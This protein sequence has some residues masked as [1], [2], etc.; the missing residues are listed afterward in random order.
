MKTI[1]KECYIEFEERKSKF[2]GYIKPVDTK[3]AAENFIAQ[4]KA[5]HKDATHNCSAYKLIENGQEYFKLNDDGEP[6][7]TAGKPMGDVINFM[8][9]CNLVVVATRYFGGIKLGA[10]GLIRAYAKTTKEAI[11]AAGIIDYIRKKELLIDLPYDKYQ[12][13]EKVIADLNIEILD[14]SYLDKIICKIL[15]PEEFIEKLKDV[16]GLTIII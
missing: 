2:I 15:L 3:E 9:V 11:N 14:K 6:S 7:G 8:D 16:D 4:I 13:L 1:S 12:N 10:G 5:K